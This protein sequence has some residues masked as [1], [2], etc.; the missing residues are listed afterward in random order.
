MKRASGE[1]KPQDKGDS[2]DFMGMLGGKEG[3][4]G[5]VGAMSGGG[6]PMSKGLQAGLST[7]NPYVA[8]GAAI[9]GIAQQ[10][11]ENKKIEKMGEARATTKLAEGEKG[12]SDIQGQIASSIRQ[13]LGSA[14]RQRQV[15]L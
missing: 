9:M 1:S 14:N 15:N 6:S 2:M 11:A 8:A 10:K 3:A 4:K 12:K 13:T 7:G 5:A